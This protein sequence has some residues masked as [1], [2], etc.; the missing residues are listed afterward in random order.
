MAARRTPEIP[1]FA[2]RWSPPTDL[3]I[4]EVGRPLCCVATTYTFHAEFFETNLLPRFLGLR[5]DNADVERAYIVERERA[6]GTAR[7]A[8]L[9]DHTHVD[10]AQSTLRWDQLA[11]RVPGGVQHAKL[12][13]LA[14]ERCVRVLVASA[15]LTRSGYRRNREMGSVLD[16][17]DHATSCPEALALQ[18]LEFVDECS[19]WTLASDD[20]RA[21]LKATIRSVMAR[22]RRWNEMPEDFT[23]GERPR[24]IFAPA[25]PR[26]NGK[27]AV[28][29]LETALSLWGSRPTHTVTVM[30]PFVGTGEGPVDPVVKRLLGVSHTRETDVR[31]VVPGRLSESDPRKTIVGLPR[32]FRDAWADAWRIAP[33]NIPTW[34]VPLSR[35]KE[36]SRDLHAKAVLL[37]GDNTSLL[38]CGSSNFSPHGMAIGVANIEANLCFIDASDAKPQGLRFE[39]RLPVNWEKDS[40]F[41]PE[42]P[43][44]VKPIEEEELSGAPLLPPFFQW[45]TFNQALG[46]LTIAIDPEYDAPIAWAIRFPGALGPTLSPIADSSSYQAGETRLHASYASLRGTNLTGL[47]TRWSD[48]AG[49]Q[50]HATL[51]VH[52]ESLDSLL[53]PEE[54]RSLSVDSIIGCLLAGREPEE[55]VEATERGGRSATSAV[56]EVDSLR[57]VDTSEYLLYRTRRLGR[58]LSTLGAR[59][60]NTIPSVEAMRYRLRQDPLGPWSLAEAIIRDWDS[61]DGGDRA[62]VVFALSE[63]S[64][65]LAHASRR[66]H[67]QRN[68]GDPDLRR[69]FAETI[70]DLNARKLASPT[71]W[72]VPNSLL[73]YMQ[74]I[75]VEC[76]GLVGQFQGAASAS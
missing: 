33:A 56:R 18:I 22:V 55:L 27:R 66:V 49:E 61:S 58:A 19:E 30:T 57:S 15:N 75:D 48:V 1:S 12:T 6:L 54:F 29:P 52:V 26:R 35:D 9:V 21:R 50:Q 3:P 41:S 67:A 23:P 5:F 60:V 28:S 40:R 73:T 2:S 53:P 46:G 11:V 39:D 14:W 65:V 45:A 24:V 42:W 4:G 17:F 13:V 69:L 74:A 63:L 64:L 72:S 62:P 34:V 25:V 32:R 51:P 37:D 43:E 47:D 31:L 20:A 36:Q 16:F 68:A 44:E 10:P 38:L 7:V 76:A 70:S 8:I 59:V 71:K